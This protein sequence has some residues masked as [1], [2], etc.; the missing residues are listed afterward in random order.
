MEINNLADANLSR[1]ARLIIEDS[2]VKLRM[3][4]LNLHPHALNVHLVIDCDAEHE[5]RKVA[6]P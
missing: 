6:R 1:A 3:G 4:L 5:F 2:D